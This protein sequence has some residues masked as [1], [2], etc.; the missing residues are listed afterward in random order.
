MSKNPQTPRPSL[1][2]FTGRAKWDA[3][4]KLGRQ[5]DQLE[6]NAW[7]QRYLDIARSL[8]WQEGVQSYSEATGG[9]LATASDE[10]TGTGDAQSSR[11]GGIGMG[12]VVSAMSQPP[13]DDQDHGTLHGFALSNNAKGLLE[14]L[15]AHSDIN[16]DSLDDYVNDFLQWQRFATF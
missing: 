11:G 16:L 12:V 14:F 9:A 1:F 4:D 8:G 3:W 5:S 13:L 15:D 7:R 6:P 2:D 10:E